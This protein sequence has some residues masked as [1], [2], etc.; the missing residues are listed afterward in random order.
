MILLLKLVLAHLLGDFL[1]QPV[2]WVNVKEALKIRAW[3][4]YLHVLIHGCLIMFFVSDFHFWPWALLL[5]GIHFLIDT[6]KLYLQT[7]NTRRIAFFADQAAHLLSILLVWV[8]KEHF[9]I[10]PEHINIGFVLFLITCIYFLTQ[11]VSLAIAIIISKWTPKTGDS[12]D[13]SLQNA[14]KY[15]GY[16]ERLLVF[17][18]ITSNHWEAV[19]FLITAKSVFRFGDLTA[20]RDRKLTEYVLIGTLLSFGIAIIAGLL[21]QQLIGMA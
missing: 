13:D 2:S 10:D 7:K 16:L 3:P 17:I 11:P 21:F 9:S 12:S 14:G 8:A 4:L 19:G 6:L 5:T 1:L 20:A 18:F 15:I